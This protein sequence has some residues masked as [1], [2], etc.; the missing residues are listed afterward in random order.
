MINLMISCTNR[1]PELSQQ[2]MGGCRSLVGKEGDRIFWHIF[3][4]TLKNFPQVS[5][6]LEKV[7]T[8]YWGPVTASVAGILTSAAVTIVLW[9]IFFKLQLKNNEDRHKHR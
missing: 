6:L 2:R 8:N 1:K 5:V 3:W 4:V 7:E 9:A